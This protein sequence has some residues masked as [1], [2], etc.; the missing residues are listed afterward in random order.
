MIAISSLIPSPL[1]RRLGWGFR[2]TTNFVPH[3]ALSQREREDNAK[4]VRL[5]TQ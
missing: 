5:L 4:V 2:H 3:P 1:E